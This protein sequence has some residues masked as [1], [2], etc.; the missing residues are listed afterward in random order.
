MVLN[1]AFT[2]VTAFKGDFGWIETFPKIALNYLSSVIFF[3][4]VIST[5]PTL[6][7]VY[8]I[9][10]YWLYFFKIVRLYN[11][12]RVFKIVNWFVPKL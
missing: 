5:Y 11:L 8:D 12:F 7:T 3:F 4:D 9:D 1:M 2:F 6:I 10:R